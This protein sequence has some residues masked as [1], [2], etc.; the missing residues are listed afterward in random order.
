M[1]RIRKL[2]LSAAA[3]V[4]LPIVANAADLAYKAPAPALPTPWSW[5]G[6]YLGANVGAGWGTTEASA[7]VGPFFLGGGVP[8]IT[9]NLPATS[10]TLN[11]F[12][13]GFQGGYNWQ[14]GSVVAGLEGDFEWSGMTGTAPCVVVLSCEVKHEWF[15]DITGRLGVVAFDKALI[16]LKGGAVWTDRNTSIGNSATIGGTTIAAMA[17][18][19]NT[20]VGGL[21]GM[22]AEYGFLP[23]WSAKLEYNFMDFGKTTTTYSFTTTPAVVL[24]GVPVTT[25]DYVHV[26]KAGV[27][28]RW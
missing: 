13:G 12:L 8:A 26:I 3:M 17:N 16:Y 24:A 23:N 6:F 4:A 18:A 20:Q 27:N 14:F 7:E 28:Y 25:N 2:L 19:S 9:A 15:A 11:G 22:G 1:V 21:L 10:Q 5:A